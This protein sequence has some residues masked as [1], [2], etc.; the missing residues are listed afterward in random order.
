MQ[1]RLPQEQDPIEVVAGEVRIG[2]ELSHFQEL[3]KVWFFTCYGI[4]AS[5]FFVLQLSV[6]LIGRLWWNGRQDRNK[7]SEEPPC[8]LDLDGSQLGG[9]FDDQWETISHRS[10]PY[11]PRESARVATSPVQTG[12]METN[13]SQQENTARRTP[14]LVHVD[15]HLQFD[16]P[17]DAV[18]NRPQ[19][20]HESARSDP[21]SVQEGAPFDTHQSVQED[22]VSCITPLVHDAQ[23]PQDTASFAT[24]SNAAA[25]RREACD[26]RESTPTTR[27][28][29]DYNGPISA[30]I[31]ESEAHVSSVS[32]PSE[33]KEGSISD[34]KFGSL[35]RQEFNNNSPRV[36]PSCL[37]S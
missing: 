12:P 23:L 13:R 7:L 34:D 21:S 33:G 28:P 20:T 27:L 15:E 5:V 11:P 31:E 14:P 2:E 25:T 16:D 36:E 17:W 29:R 19:P 24:P 26:P 10:D 4:G 22:D 3:L 37:P 32:L 35:T 6:W 9:E 8:D 30:P 18:S 1:S